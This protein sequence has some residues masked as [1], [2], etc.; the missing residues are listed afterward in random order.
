M[1]HAKRL[2]ITHPVSK[3]T[4]TFESALPRDMEDILKSLDEID[5]VVS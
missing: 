2:T 1:L 4:M 5:K 3:E